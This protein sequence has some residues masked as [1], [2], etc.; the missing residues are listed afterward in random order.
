LLRLGYKIQDEIFRMM[1]PSR[2]DNSFCKFIPT[3]AGKNINFQNW[4]KLIGKYIYAGESELDKHRN[5]KCRHDHYASTRY[6]WININNFSTSSGKPT[7]ECRC[8]GA[9]MNYEKIRNWV[10]IC[11]CIVSYAENNQKKIWYNI[12]DVTLK[13]VILEGLGENL[14]KQVYTYYTKRVAEFAGPIQDSGKELPSQL[15]T[16]E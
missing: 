10:L 8:H 12:D 6:R 15:V 5:K 2:L 16:I 4:R 13:N 3:W 1:P 7:V 9:S 14:G 11:K